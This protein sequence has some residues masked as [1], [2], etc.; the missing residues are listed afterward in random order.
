MYPR[1][2]AGDFVSVLRPHRPKN[3]DGKVVRGTDGVPRLVVSAQ[4][5]V[6]VPAASLADLV[7][8]TEW[9]AR[10]W[11]DGQ[12][13]WLESTGG[14]EEAYGEQV[15]SVADTIRLAL[16]GIG[17]ITQWRHRIDT[18]P[19]SCARLRRWCPHRFSREASRNLTHALLSYILL[20]LGS[21][22]PLPV[23]S[24]EVLLAAL[25][26]RN[27]AIEGDAETVDA[28]S[29][30]WLG[31]T[32]PAQW[33]KAVEMALLGDCVDQLGIGM[34][35][36]LVVAE[37]LRRHSNSEHRQLQPLW[38]RRVHGKNVALLS[39]P[40]DDGLSLADVLA[41]PRLLE[42]TVL[43]DKF[44]DSRIDSVLRRL[45]EAEED[46]AL[47]WARSTDSWAQAA[48]AAGHP[49]TYG[50]RV[51]RKLKRLGE[52]HTARTAAAG[53]AAR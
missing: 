42:D 51:R 40:V 53:M 7:M 36:D 28:F 16:R 30:T 27:A 12:L 25:I 26:A 29:R 32:R 24:R 45:H 14:A 3:M 23:L 20:E 5:Q 44:T 19:C 10:T 2:I 17:S 49:D 48:L 46:L 31:L 13:D 52:Q 18:L 35:D 21:A 9:Q 37:L 22:C 38:E 11:H 47:G 34:T 39:Y 33:R 41:D 43:K 15:A 8:Y 1:L 4:I 50:E 6:S